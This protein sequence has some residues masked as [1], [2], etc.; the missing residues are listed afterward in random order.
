MPMALARTL[1]ATTTDHET[2]Y[3]GL[4]T[5]A[6]DAG[7]LIL[8]D[9]R[10]IVHC[11]AA[12]SALFGLPIDEIVAMGFEGLLERLRASVPSFP[13]N[14]GKPI[15]WGRETRTVCEEFESREPRSAIRWLARSYAEPTCAEVIIC[16][17]ITTEMDLASTYQRLAVTDALTGLANRR[18]I[19]QHIRR[20]VA[21]VVRHGYRLTFVMLDIDHFKRV[22]DRFGH[23]IGDEVLRRVSDAVANTLRASDMAAR[24][25]GEEFLIVLTDTG[26]E[27][28]RLCAERIRM[29]VEALNIPRVGE[30]TISAGTSELLQGEDL[31]IALLRADELLYKA[32]A[33]GRNCVRS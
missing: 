5:D 20:E 10:A 24:W 3:L 30:V 14:L 22:N 29:A 32:K 28:G 4:L 26:L 33:A 9:T 11:N 15:D 27:G 8:D 16:T 1:S 18:G 2:G 21:R 19:D 17:D 31:S 23:G 12:F 7:I 13:S 6:L 25:G